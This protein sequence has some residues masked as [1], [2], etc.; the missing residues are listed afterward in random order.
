M[1]FPADEE[2]HKKIDMMPSV[3][4]RSYGFDWGQAN[5]CRHGME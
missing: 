1:S 2:E 3:Y 5:E 4:Q